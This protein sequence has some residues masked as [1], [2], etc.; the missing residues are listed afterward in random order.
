[1]IN[2]LLGQFL[3]PKPKFIGDNGTTAQTKLELNLK[4]PVFMLPKECLTTKNSTIDSLGT[5]VIKGV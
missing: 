2:I 4:D 5:I 3:L 1:M